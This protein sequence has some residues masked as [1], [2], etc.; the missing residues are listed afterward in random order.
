MPVLEMTSEEK[1][2]LLAI[3]ERYYPDL[4]SERANT[5]DR[6]YRKDLENRE[7]CMGRLIDRIKK[8]S[9]S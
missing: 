9:D 2:E 8:I 4:R 3:L 6:E 7:K 5:E 1:R